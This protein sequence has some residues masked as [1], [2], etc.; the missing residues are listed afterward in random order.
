MT[1]TQQPLAL[2]LGARTVMVNL[3]TVRIVRNNLDAES[4]IAMVD[5]FV[6]PEHL[7][8]VFNIAQRRDARRRELRFWAT[9]IIAP[10]F[11]AKFTIDEAIAS[12]IGGKDTFRRSEIEMQWV[13]SADLIGSL[14]ESGELVEA[15]NR[16]L[17]TSLKNF[18]RRRWISAPAQVPSILTTKIL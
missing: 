5:N 6:H 4:I 14:V 12:I 11:T 18:L 8:F 1:A 2:K 10:E 9:E 13:C 15:G 3:E 7:Q 17:S 16:I